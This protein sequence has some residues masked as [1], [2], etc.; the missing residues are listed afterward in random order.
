MYVGDT[1]RRRTDRMHNAFLRIHADVRL[2]AEVPLIAFARL[3]HCRVAFFLLVLR[4]AGRVDDRRINNR[5]GR[6]ADAARGQ[7]QV[8]RIEH[9]TA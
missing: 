5:A 8:H 6:D 1:G 7:V 3:M 2:H 4:R 9:L